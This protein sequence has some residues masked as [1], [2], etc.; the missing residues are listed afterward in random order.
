MKNTGIVRKI[1][2]L[3]RIVLPKEMRRTMKIKEGDPL[4]IFVDE[5]KIVLQKYWSGH[6]CP[7][8]EEKEES[9]LVRL[10]NGKV[11]CKSCALEFF[12]FIE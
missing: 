2:E 4:E 8:C 12:D 7:H 3:G 5:D 9:K 6:K 11:I 1:D 10:P